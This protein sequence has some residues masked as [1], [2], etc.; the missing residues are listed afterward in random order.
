[1]IALLWLSDAESLIMVINV[2]KIKKIIL[3]TFL[4]V[5]EIWLPLRLWTF[6]VYQNILET[7]IERPLDEESLPF[8]KSSTRSPLK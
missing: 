5:V 4:I 6:F 7:S 2:I 1:M 8:D 3:S